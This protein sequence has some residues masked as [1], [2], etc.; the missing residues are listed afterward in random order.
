MDLY[1]PYFVITLQNGEIVGIPAPSVDFNN[2]ETALYAFASHIAQMPFII[3]PEGLFYCDKIASI[4]IGTRPVDK[5]QP[6][7]VI[8]IKD[9]G[10]LNFDI[11]QLEFKF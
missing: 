5:R 6:A 8:P 1:Q 7:R 10:Q 3:T 9:P 2:K 11:S 4:K